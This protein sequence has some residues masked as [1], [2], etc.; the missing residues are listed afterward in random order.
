MASGCV[1]S[2][3]LYAKGLTGKS[4]TVMLLPTSVPASFSQLFPYTGLQQSFTLLEGNLTCNFTI[5]GTQYQDLLG[6]Q[7]YIL[8][9]CYANNRQYW[10]NTNHF[11]LTPPVIQ[12]CNGGAHLGAIFKRQPY[13]GKYGP[14]YE[15][16]PALTP[17]SHSIW[18]TLI[19]TGQ[20]TEND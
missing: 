10:A 7:L 20:A 6:Q 1:V 12:P 18:G 8:V 16:T 11:N 15:G 17:D 9:S 19:S 14:A 13:K 2:F 5:T 4:V 3:D